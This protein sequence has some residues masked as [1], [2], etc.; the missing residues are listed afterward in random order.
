MK[1]NLQFRIARFLLPSLCL[2][3]TFDQLDAQ[4]YKQNMEKYWLYRQRLNQT[5]LVVGAGQGESIPAEFYD[6]SYD[7]PGGP[8]SFAIANKSVLAWSD[9]TGHLGYYIAMLATERHLLYLT[10]N[11]TDKTEMELF[12]A[13]NA[14]WRLDA[15]SGYYGYESTNYDLGDCYA[16]NMAIPGPMNFSNYNDANL[17]D[18]FFMRD[19]VPPSF[20]QHWSNLDTLASNLT[21]PNSHNCKAKEMSQDQVFSILIGLMC[22]KTYVPANLHYNGVPLREFAIFEA[23]RILEWCKGN[24][25]W[26]I[27]NPHLSGAPR[28]DN[29]GAHGLG[30]SAGE[31]YAGI[32]F[33]NGSNN[34]TNLVSILENPFWQA[35]Q[36]PFYL[37]SGAR[38]NIEPLIASLAAVGNSWGP[39]PVVA[40]PNIGNPIFLILGTAALQYVTCLN[41]YGATVGDTR[42]GLDKYAGRAKEA[43]YI[44]HHLIYNS[45]WSQSNNVSEATILA[46]L[47]SA[48]C[49]GPYS[50]WPN[51]GIYGWTTANRFFFPRK[52]SDGSINNLETGRIG[53]YGQIYNGIDYMLLHNL[54]YLWRFKHGLDNPFEYPFE[55]LSEA[56]IDHDWPIQ[57]P[58]MQ[59]YNGSRLMPI[60]LRSIHNITARH[61]VKAFANQPA[62]Y[63]WN[64]DVTYRAGDWIELRDGFEVEYGADF[65]AFIGP[66]ECVNGQILR[67]DGGMSEDEL[68]IKAI[69]D[70]ADAEYDSL[71]AILLDSLNMT[72][73]EYAALWDSLYF[74]IQDSFYLDSSARRG[75]FPTET[76]ISFDV[77]PNPTNGN[78]TI[79][80]QL[81]AAE[82]ISIHLL[83]MDC[84]VGTELMPKT[85]L[86]A[87]THEIPVSLADYAAGLYHVI[88]KRASGVA[89]K[90]VAKLE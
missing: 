42:R 67:T 33:S 88:M 77:F 21:A 34:L 51:Q 69:Y 89:S 35:L 18:G 80:I 36:H 9:A 4:D 70:A 46:M 57:A 40:Y 82:E 17:L 66:M 86:V 26:V 20:V 64:G 53:S 1:I 19:D 75:N 8:F 27:R 48:P 6:D 7:S 61:K 76:D 44:L 5:F 11:S 47:N 90:S 72:E 60:F 58:M 55:N 31:V 84:K 32:H 87:G 74:S 49:E 41:T 65:E 28:V 43:Q 10:G 3:L 13:L 68:L 52:S 29:S 24:G 2:L 73:T 63:G 30:F 12:F 59:V 39:C 78:F 62:N 14:L 15:T 37:V 23:N 54:Y 79:S 83:S 22:V 81:P 71:H 38:Y 16:P 56:T 85:L 45:N 50:P 25:D